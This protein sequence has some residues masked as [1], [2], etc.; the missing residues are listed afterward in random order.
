VA[1]SPSIRVAVSSTA[2]AWPTEVPETDAIQAEASRCSPS[3]RHAPVAITRRAASA[4]P[5]AA[6]RSMRANAST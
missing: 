4:F 3:W 5:A 2:A 6:S 1:S